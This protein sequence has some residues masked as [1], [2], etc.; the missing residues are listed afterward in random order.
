MGKRVPFLLVLVAFL[1]I[2]ALGFLIFDDFGGYYWGSGGYYVRSRNWEYLNILHPISGPF[3]GIQILCTLSVLVMMI[4]GLFNKRMGSR[5]VLFITSIIL[6]GIVFLL[7]VIGGITVAITGET[8]DYD[9]WW[10][11]GT[12]YAG[13]SGPVLMFIPLLIMTIKGGKPNL[14]EE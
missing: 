4:I 11:G 6:N 12:F 7:A 1:C 9:D 13:L 8:G 2:V 14:I 10:L 5:K 3:I